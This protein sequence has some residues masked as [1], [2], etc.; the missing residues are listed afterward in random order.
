MARQSHA[1]AHKAVLLALHS[2]N[3]KVKALFAWPNLKQ[4]IMDFVN[5]C[6]VCA[7]AKPEHC[8][9]PGLLQPL[10]VPTH[11]CHT[12]SLDFI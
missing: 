6:E 3:N 5:A 2:T 11:A 1:E 7:Q 12:I 8:R 10:P 9:L 4:Y